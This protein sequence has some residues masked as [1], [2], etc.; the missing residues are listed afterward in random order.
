MLAAFGSEACGISVAD[1]EAPAQAASARN[2]TTYR[3]SESTFVAPG[4]VLKIDGFATAA[5]RRTKR[6]LRSADVCLRCRV[7]TSQ[8]RVVVARS[9]LLMVMR[10]RF[11]NV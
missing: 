3:T 9:T 4:E 6:F 10:K 5:A 7:R 1:L 2:E 8:S 11:R